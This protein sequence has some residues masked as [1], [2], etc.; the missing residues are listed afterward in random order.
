[1][2]EIYSEVYHNL[3]SLSSTNFIWSILE[4]L[5]PYNTKIGMASLRRFAKREQFDVGYFF[6]YN[7]QKK[8]NQVNKPNVS[9]K[10][11]SINLQLS[12]S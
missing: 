12:Q 1:M 5:D 10:T 8:K 9:M 3:F 11:F 7:K 6:P 4:Y 2:K